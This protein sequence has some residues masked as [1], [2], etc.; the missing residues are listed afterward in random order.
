MDIQLITTSNRHYEWSQALA[1]HKGFSGYLRTIPIKTELGLSGC[2]IDDVFTNYYPAL[3]NRAKRPTKQAF[4]AALLAI[5]STFKEEKEHAEQTGF[6]CALSNTHRRMV[7]RYKQNDFSMNKLGEVLNDLATRGLLERHDGFRGEGYPTGLA[8]LWL[9]TEQA[10]ELLESLGN[11]VMVKPFVGTPESIILKGKA[12]NLVD[13]RETEETIL[14]RSEL[15]K[16]NSYRQS[17]SC[18]YRP[19]IGTQEATGELL[20]SNHYV[21]IKPYDLTFKRLFNGSFRIGGRFYGGVQQLRGI[22]RSTIIMN[23]SP[24]VEQ[25]IKSMHIRMLYNIEGLE[26]PT[27]GYDIEGYDRETFKKVSLI[28]L[29]AK[30]KRSAIGAIAK[31]LRESFSY[32]KSVLECFERAHQ[33][34]AKYFYTSTWEMLQ[35]MDGE[36]ARR[37]QL[38]ATAAS[39][40]IIP[41]HDS[42][43]TMREHSERLSDIINSEYEQRFG[44]LPV[45]E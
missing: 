20:L 11:D 15:F 28:A 40:P 27:D 41:I 24:T 16:S 3:A 36:L 23:G 43:I 30:S 35:Y 4:Q 31:S 21:D 9:P 10:K 25:D 45:I 34:I 5:A 12:G 33:H 22:E 19:V 8:T 38:A 44:F 39:I 17:I 29:N 14:M 18:S 2:S 37:V 32:A 26:A 1:K 42:F 13:Y 6:V 7:Q